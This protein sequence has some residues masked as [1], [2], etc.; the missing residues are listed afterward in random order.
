MSAPAAARL[1]VL[2]AAPAIAVSACNRQSVERTD[3]GSTTAERPTDAALETT[4]RAR[5]Y[6]EPATRGD[7]I[8]VSAANGVITLRGAVD[9]AAVEQNALDIARGTSGATSVQDQLTVDTAPRPAAG[10]AQERRDQAPLSATPAWITTKI[11]AQ[12]FV[13]PDVKPWNVDVTTTS[14]G[15]VELS[16][17][18][19]SAEAKAEALR[20]ARETEGVT[21]VEDRLRVRTDQPGT[22]DPD[23][24]EVDTSDPWLT[25]KIRAKYFLD[26]DVKALD[27]NVTT[28]DGVVTLRGTVD[29][30]MA[31]RHAVA[32]AR[33]TDGVR[34]V[35]DELA[36]GGEEPRGTSGRI[37]S[38]VEDP[39]ITT[40]IQS[41]YFLE[42]DVKGRSIDV[43]TKNGVVTLSGSV[44]SAAERELAERIARET[45]GVARI[46]N[47]LKTTTAP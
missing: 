41:K 5:L 15:V 6:E 13:D 18:V 1:L 39:W 7:D 2:L 33:N 16:G 43:D 36:V 45:E 38:G 28:E 22:G 12:Y 24:A 35:R 27:V 26:G 31:R 8:E 11:Q 37:V 10:P 14:E 3:T 32:I 9:T 23:R 30:E 4:V 20:I 19:D 29:S 46:V 42:P 17:E 25:A 21:R 34:D 47:Q 44:A 40:K